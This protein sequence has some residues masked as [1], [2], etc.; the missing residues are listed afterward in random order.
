[1]ADIIKSDKAGRGIHS[2]YVYRLVANILFPGYPYYS[3]REID[4]FGEGCF[5]P[6]DLKI[7]FNLVNFIQ[8]GEVRFVGFSDPALKKV[9]SLAKS[10]LVFFEERQISGAGVNRLV[11]I[12]SQSQI[13]EPEFIPNGGEVWVITGIKPK[14][15]C[16][17]AER[18]DQMNNPGALIRLNRLVLV[19]FNNKL[20]GQCYVIKH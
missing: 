11:F 19:L 16:P 5:K 6:E 4:G 20:P 13:P 2:P 18:M 8:P 10:T 17:F 3:Y 1:M 12:D 7:I 9:C 15:S 14:E